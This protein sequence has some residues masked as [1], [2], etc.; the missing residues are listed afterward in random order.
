MDE[1]TPATGHG[2]H[3]FVEIAPAAVALP[4]TTLRG[5]VPGASWSY[6]LPS[7]ELGRVVCLGAGP[8]AELATL[9]RIGREVVVVDPLAKGDPAAIANVR[10]AP[11]FSSLDLADASVDLVRIA[12]GAS[13]AGPSPTEIARLGRLLAPDGRVYLEESPES[14]VRSNRSRD[15]YLEQGLAVAGEF[16]LHPSRGEPREALPV[17]DPGVLAYVAR[18]RFAG[19]PRRVRLAGRLQAVGLGRPPA[20]TAILL[21]RADVATP[22]TGPPDYFANL[23]DSAGLEV[24]RRWCLL[25]RGQFNSQKVLAVGFPAQ[26]EEPNLIVKLP[27]EPALDARLENELR[28]LRA[29]EAVP[30]AAG[31]VPRALASGR[32]GGL[33][34]LAESFVVGRPF[35]DA[36]KGAHGMAALRDAVTF[37][38][39][40]GRQTAVPAEPGALAAELRGILERFAVLYRIEPRHARA[41]EALVGSVADHRGTLPRV[42]QHGDPGVWNLFVTPRGVVAFLDWESAE[43][44]GAP[45]W[46]VLYVL[47]SYVVS[48]GRLWGFR[49]RTEAFARTFV[50]HSPLSTM[51][52]DAVDGYR[53]AIDLPAA[54]V[55]PLFVTCWMHRAVKEAS[56]LAPERREHGN[57]VRLVRLCLDADGPT[58]NRLRGESTG[59]IEPPEPAGDG[60]TGR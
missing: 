6:L 40:L 59:R 53:R 35:R 42:F 51:V 47:R 56:R 5:Q 25:A 12:G 16:V 48:A 2:N 24:P 19:A 26:G 15:A 22:R 43:P 20:R 29:L 41:L 23:L 36:G 50:G 14:S 32:H 33:S 13:G 28:V 52:L 3:G 27:R 10:L 21:A 37:L 31:R 9:A 38:G 17:G 46:D 30:A 39:D 7:L 8:A 34:I 11:D 44:H 60:E 18:T 1:P 54:L 49:R 57:Y 55:H 58:L 4:A 45:L